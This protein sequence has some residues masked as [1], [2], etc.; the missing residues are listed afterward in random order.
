MADT[1]QEKTES[2]TPRKREE[3]YREGKVPRSQELGTAALLLTAALSVQVLSPVLGGAVRDNFGAGLHFARAGVR[4]VNGALG[5][6]AGVMQTMLGALLVVLA[7]TA[8]CGMMVG[9]AQGRGV[10]A[11]KALEPS[12]KKMNP[13]ANARRTIGVQPWAELVKSLLKL[14]VIG[15]AVY[16]SLGAA[17]EDVLALSQE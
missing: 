13:V 17:W 3:A 10:I 7:A 8:A 5:M 15:L 1:D 4:D 9:A 2:A 12:L 16:F 6:L 11:T 14:I